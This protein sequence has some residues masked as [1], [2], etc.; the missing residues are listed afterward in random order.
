M[1]QFPEADIHKWVEDYKLLIPI[2]LPIKCESA[3]Q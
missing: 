2:S 3:Q 1:I